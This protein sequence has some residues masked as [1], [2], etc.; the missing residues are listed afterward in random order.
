MIPKA[1]K[2][3][4]SDVD[5]PRGR[6]YDGG[7]AYTRNKR[8]RQRL[9]VLL[10]ELGLADTREKARALIMAGAVLVND[11][12]ATKP[13]KEVPVASDVRLRAQLPYVSRGGLKLELT[14]NRLTLTGAFSNLAGDFDANVAGGSH[15]HIGAPGENGGLDITLAPTL[16]AD[17][18]SGIY[19]AEDNAIELTG[20]QVATLRAGN[21]YFN[22]HTTEFAGGELRSQILPEINFFPSD[23]AAIT[24]P[25]DGAAITIAGNP[26]TPF[27]PQW[28][29][30]S[31]RDQLAYIWQLSAT[32]DF[33]AL[34]VNQNV[35]A[36]QVF[37]TT[38]GVVDVLLESA[39]VGLNESITLYHRAL[40][41]DGSVA[42]PGAS[43]M[44]WELRRHAPQAATT[45]SSS[46]KHRA[47]IRAK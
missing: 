44:A 13:G 47:I 4:N 18:K 25:A 40:A 39:G 2:P 14:G 3:V 41:S 29:M 24:V 1:W 5:E 19:T 31:D 34:L 10:V 30:A 28:D 15:L 9:D 8:G 12:P 23:E 32:D 22:L 36:N 11:E 45:A 38:F 43:A 7:M 37:E 33:S 42:T 20:E 16:A 6:G 17:L 46:A 35:G 21:N 27:S 26:D